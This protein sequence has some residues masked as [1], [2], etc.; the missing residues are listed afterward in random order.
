[1]IDSYT[2]TKD[3]IYKGERY[4]VRD[5]GAVMRHAREGK[6]VR[7][8]DGV[9][10]FGIKSPQDGYLYF[11][12]VGGHRIHIIVANAFLGVR[13]SKVYV[14][15]HIDT[16]R[17]N[18][19]V[20]NLRWL[21]RLENILNNEITRN[22][23]IYLCGSIEAFIENPAILRERSTGDPSLDWMRTVTQEE[24]KI[25]YENVKKYW[26]EQ[27]KDPKPLIGSKMDQRV[28]QPTS[29]QKL[30]TSISAD[31][32]NPSSNRTSYVISPSEW[33]EMIK[34]LSKPRVPAVVTPS[35][36]TL[37]EQCDTFE[38]KQH[39]TFGKDI[40][41]S[42][43][44]KAAQSNEFYDNKRFEYPSTPQGEYDNPLQAYADALYE[45]APF[46]RG[47]NGKREYVAVRWAFSNNKES[48]LVITQSAY[49]WRSDGN[50]DVVETPISTLAK[51]EYEEAEINYSLNEIEYR[52]GVYIHTRPVDGFLP[53]E[54]I[55]EVFDNMTTK[56]N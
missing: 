40:I 25:A 53:L 37:I 27:V 19:R 36:D 20:E 34:P 41:M 42:L 39:A 29:A 55:E 7:K 3:C 18:N 43:T 21:T 38:K 17:C 35:T 5:N 13:D 54:Y 47:N 16:N 44:P 52:D 51:N 14:V 49:V 45:G 30:E 2:E 48:L 32:I 56:Q 46:W 1:M 31:T 24:A 12:Y 23:I 50:G 15:D 8:D 28:Y 4:S 11:G 26:E 9:W 6:R 22:K 33:S 10:T